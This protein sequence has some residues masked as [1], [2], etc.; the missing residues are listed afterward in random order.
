MTGLSTTANIS[1]EITLLAGNTRI[2]RPAAA[3]IIIL[4]IVIS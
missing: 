3:I 2:P 4:R 1:F